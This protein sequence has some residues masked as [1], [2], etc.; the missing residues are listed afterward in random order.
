MPTK[1][2]KLAANREKAAASRKRH[3]RDKMLKGISELE[4]MKLGGLQGASFGFAD[5]IEAGVKSILN[6]DP[7]KDGQSILKDI[8]QEYANA[9]DANRKSYAVGEIGTGLLTGLIPGVGV[10]AIPKALRGASLATKMLRASKIAAPVAAGSAALSSAGHHNTFSDEFQWSQLIGDVSKSTMLGAVI[11]AAAAPTIA[12]AGGAMKKATELSEKWLA[13]ATAKTAAEKA[14][15]VAIKAQREAAKQAAEA[16]LAEIK[17]LVEDANPVGKRQT[18]EIIKT[19]AVGKPSSPGYK[20]AT[21]EEVVKLVPETAKQ[22][23]QRKLAIERQTIDLQKQE[24]AR[25][26]AQAGYERSLPKT[27]EERMKDVLQNSSGTGFNFTD[28]IRL[29]SAGKAAVMKVVAP[30]ARGTQEGVT[31]L[32]RQLTD[33]NFHINPAVGVGSTSGQGDEFDSYMTKFRGR[34]E[35]K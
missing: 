13:K 33:A 14:E 21:T 17:Q 35:L 18:K 9:E 31:W 2:E 4:S 11:G 25:L 7:S 28:L 6:N 19:P 8:R 10:A 5:E 22:A 24:L 34:K 20:P 3:E 12:A 32:G 30:V 29:G 16:R 26:N 1:A 23:A 15:N 27:A